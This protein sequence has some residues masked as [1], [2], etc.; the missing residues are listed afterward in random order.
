MR[1]SDYVGLGMGKVLGMA[2]FDLKAFLWLGN[3]KRTA[4]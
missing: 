1:R 4:T 3:Q 2:Q